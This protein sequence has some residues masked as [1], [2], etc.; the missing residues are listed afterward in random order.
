MITQYSFTFSFDG[1]PYVFHDEV[2]TRTTNA[3]DVFPENYRQ[4]ADMFTMDEL[5]ELDAG[6]WFAR[7]SIMFKGRL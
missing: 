7:V 4:P 6:S 2:L 3:I 1:V 5:R